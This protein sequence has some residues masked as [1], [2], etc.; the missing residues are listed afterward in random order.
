MFNRMPFSVGAMKIRTLPLVVSAA[1]LL[2]G[3]STTVIAQELR[4]GASVLDRPKP[5][6]DPLG[7]RAGS[8]LIFPKVELGTAYDDN[9]FATEN[10]EEG[11]F[12]FQV[13]PT[14]TVQSDFSR[15]LLRFSAGRG[16]RPLCGQTSENYIDYFF[17]GGGRFDVT[18]DAALSTNVPTAS[19]TRTAVIPT[20]RHRERADRI[21]PDQCGTGLPAALQPGDRPG[22]HRGRER[23]LRRRRVDHR[24]DVGPGRP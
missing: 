6:L 22:R 8:F 2:A 19:C 4:R 24:R 18:G 1:V 9:V 17:T 5:E 11:D 3:T 20:R 23:R 16:Y 21:L 13:L 10:N 14:V 12:L 7:V 15:H